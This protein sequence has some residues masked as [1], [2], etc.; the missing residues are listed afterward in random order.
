MATDFRS[1]I[2][3]GAKSSA[4]KVFSKTARAGGKVADSL[5]NIAKA[6]ILAGAAIGGAF[7]LSAIKKAG[8][9][10]SAVADLVR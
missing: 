3:L 4:E 6:G 1:R 5:K 10:E 2:I 9:F 8:Q 7:A